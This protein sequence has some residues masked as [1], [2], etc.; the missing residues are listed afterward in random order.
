MCIRR[1]DTSATETRLT[2]ISLNLKI[3]CQL[4]V[5]SVTLLPRSQEDVFLG[6]SRFASVASLSL[7]GSLLVDT[8]SCYL[9]HLCSSFFPYSVP[10][11]SASRKPGSLEEKEFVKRSRRYWEYLVDDLLTQPKANIG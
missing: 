5:M 9:A 3:L 1:M 2:L 10:V 8:C 7:S 6:G 4:D 11:Q